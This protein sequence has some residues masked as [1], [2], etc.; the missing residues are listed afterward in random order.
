MKKFAPALFLILLFACKK[1]NTTSSS[2]SWTKTSTFVGA[3]PTF[4]PGANKWTQQ[5]DFPGGMR[6]AALG[7]SGGN[8]SY[9]GFGH[10]ASTGY[11][12]FWE[13]KP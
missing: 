13:F 5:A 10:D 9:Y 6:G 11:T 7:F 1:H 4:D 2:G 3:I 12:D 8:A